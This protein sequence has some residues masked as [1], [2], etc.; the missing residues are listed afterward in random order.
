MDLLYAA[1]KAASELGKQ[2]NKASELEKHISPVKGCPRSGPRTRD[3]GVIKMPELEPHKT[4]QFELK[5]LASHVAGPA[6]PRPNQVRSGNVSII[7][8]RPVR[9]LSQSS[10]AVENYNN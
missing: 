8:G 4:F 1:T 5:K 7:I 9:Y 10:T 6:K 2:I 3:L